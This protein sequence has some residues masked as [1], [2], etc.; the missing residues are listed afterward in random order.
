MNIVSGACPTGHE[1]L[2]ICRVRYDASK[3]A[4]KPLYSGVLRYD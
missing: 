3:A 2:G 1:K 4:P